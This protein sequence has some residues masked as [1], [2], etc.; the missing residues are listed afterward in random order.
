V[1]AALIAL[2]ELTILAVIGLVALVTQVATAVF[3]AVFG[4]AGAQ[5]QT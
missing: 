3:R 2:L 1:T 4:R 5:P